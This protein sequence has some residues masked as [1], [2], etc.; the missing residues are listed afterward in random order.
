MYIVAQMD[1]TKIWQIIYAFL[2]RLTRRIVHA[3]EIVCVSQSMVKRWKTAQQIVDVEITTVNMS[4]EKHLTIVQ[5][6]A[7]Y[8]EMV[9]ATHLRAVHLASKTVGHV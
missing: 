1:M 9:N 6:I 4:L 5:K 2:N 3:M 7:V 8:V